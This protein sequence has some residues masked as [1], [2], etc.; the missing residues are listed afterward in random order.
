MKCPDYNSKNLMKHL[1]EIQIR[2]PFVLP[3]NDEGLYYLYGT[4][5]VDPGW[6]TPGG[7]FD[8]YTSRD[9]E[10]WEGP[11]PAYRP[12]GELAQNTCF[13]APEV[14][15]YQGRYYLFASIGTEQQRG[16]YVFVA[17]TPRGPFLPHSKG[18]VTPPAWLSIDGTLYIDEHDQPWCVFV[19]EYWQIRDGSMCAVRLAKDLSEALDEPVAL[20]FASSAPWLGELSDEQR[21]SENFVTD[22]PFLHRTQDG[23]LLMLWSSYVKGV[24][25]LGT[26]RSDNGHILGP[27]QH[28]EELIYSDDGGHGMLFHTFAGQLMLALHTQKAGWGHERAVF[29]PLIERDGKLLVS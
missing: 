23:A 15:F 4:T 29:I 6:E 19:H 16:T 3:Q 5:D 12:A 28:H 17:D 2:D 21:Q 13:W 25:V 14:F 8:V 10:Q 18:P 20:F 1:S 27:W 9:L 7:G 11:Q 26:L 24:Y 22:G